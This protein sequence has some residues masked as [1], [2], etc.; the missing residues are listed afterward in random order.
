MEDANL[1]INV[2]TKFQ[3]SGAKDAAQSLGQVAQ[4]AK[5]AQS[6][7]DNTS[8]NL[9]GLSDQAKGV[10]ASFSL[11]T[12]TLGALAIPAFVIHSVSTYS[13]TVK[14]ATSLGNE[15]SL[16]MEGVE[17]ATYN[18]GKAIVTAILPD[19]K[20][21]VEK[22]KEAAGWVQKAADWW[23]GTGGEK[24]AKEKANQTI[25]DIADL[26]RLGMAQ[27]KDVWEGLMSGKANIEDIFSGKPYYGENSKKVLD[28]ILAER[29]KG[30][31]AEGET[32]ESGQ[33]MTR[34]RILEYRQLQIQEQEQLIAFNRQR[35]LI[36][37]SFE[38]QEE[39]AQFDFQKTRYRSERDFHRQLSYANEDFYKTQYRSI[40]D[41]QRQESITVEAY[42]RQRAIASRDFQIGLARNEEDF[43]RQRSR[44]QYD[45]NWSI[46]MAM[47][48]GDAM[49]VWQ[50]NRQFKIEKRR[51][52]EDYQIS[53]TR[54]VEDFQ[55]SQAD[56]V[57]NFQIERNNA[58]I[59]FEISRADA[60]MDFEI[61]RKRTLEQYLIQR[62]DQEEDYKIQRERAAYQ[63]QLQLEDMQWQFN[64]EVRQRRLAFVEKHLPELMLEADVAA[65]VLASIPIAIINSYNELLGQVGSGAAGLVKGYANG[66]YV[67]GGG[68]VHDGEFVLNRDTVNAAEALSRNRQLSQDNILSMMSSGTNIVNNFSRGMSSDEKY[69]LERQFEQLVGAFRK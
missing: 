45:H 39:Y 12:K 27:A 8:K 62:K 36:N 43:Q 6:R 14:S 46:R 65:K 56:E 35:Y 25:D 61:N 34:A 1:N 30:K 42:N 7:V 41:F 10:N 59:Q 17:E 60:V 55:R 52:E 69:L 48:E 44:A 2:I 49:A 47:L 68:R 40:R 51:A 15:W 63:F 54:S 66:G 11:I 31:P 57:R 16:A 38:K 4:H 26:K 58:K 3:G 37:R 19:M 22:A 24:S 53:R 28:E 64:E 23:S 67:V 20:N 9:G 5:D 18:V 21:F 50:S 29:D 13:N 32:A 33:K